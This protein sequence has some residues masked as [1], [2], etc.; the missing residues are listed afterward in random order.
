MTT[1]GISGTGKPGATGA[2]TSHSLGH[3]CEL[4]PHR[5]FRQATQTNSSLST[6]PSASFRG[7]RVF[8]TE[9]QVLSAHGR[10]NR[11]RRGAALMMNRRLA[12]VA[13]LLVSTLATGN[14]GHTQQ[15]SLPPAAVQPAAA[16]QE[17][18]EVLARG[19]IHEAFAE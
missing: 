12:I 6:S 3:R 19:P 8:S 7:V 10:I 17:G 15:P 16:Q 13:G 18:M 9:E 4:A 1:L 5:S 14:A 2:A 11:L